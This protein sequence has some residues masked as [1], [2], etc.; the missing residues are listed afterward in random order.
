[1]NLADVFTVV[2]VV[3]ALLTVFVAL[4]LLTAALF[5]RLAERCA[6]HLGH[7]PAACAGAGLLMIVPVVAVGFL[8]SRAAPNAAG[9]LAAAIFFIGTLLAGLMGSTGLALRIGRGLAAADDPQAP[10]RQVRRGGIVLAFTFL[11]IVTL[12]LVLIPGLGA[13]GLALLRGDRVTVP[14]AA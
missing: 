11:I 10:W 8:L 9:R 14:P 7:S 3:L 6:D 1:M 5:P 4:W 12:P 13:L 2:L